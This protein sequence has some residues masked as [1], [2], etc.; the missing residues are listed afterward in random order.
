MHVSIA[1]AALKGAV[2][3]ACNSPVVRFR[4]SISVR[5]ATAAVGRAFVHQLASKREFAHCATA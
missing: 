2:F 4:P 5:G 1:A 3:I